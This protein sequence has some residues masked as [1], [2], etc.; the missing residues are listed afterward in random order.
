[1]NDIFKE[2][3]IEYIIENYPNMKSLIN[4]NELEV[5]QIPGLTKTKAKYF[6]AYLKLSRELLTAGEKTV[7]IK[8]PGDIYQNLKDISFFEEERFIIVLLDTKNKVITHVEI[9]K[10]IINASIVHPREV[11]APAI[12]MKAN[13]IICCHNH[14]SG[15]PTPSSEDISIT[16]RLRDVGELLGI[17]LLDH[18]IIGD[19][20]FYSMKERG[21]M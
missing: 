17:R 4:A 20:Q 19:N 14:P 1:M 21:M 3:T 8:S 16:N 11:F 9:S 10:G 15:D 7:K 6:N 12:R 5:N 13:S 2:E 18:I